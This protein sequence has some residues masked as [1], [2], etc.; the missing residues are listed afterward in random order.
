[1]KIKGVLRIGF[2]CVLFGLAPAAWAWTATTTFTVT[3]TVVPTCT[4]SAAAL[5]FGTTIP[6]PINSNVEATG[7][8]V[9]TCSS[10][11]GYAIALN[12]GN[13]SGATFASRK[14]SSGASRLNYSLFT[15]AG[16]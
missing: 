3:A 10:G 15:D 12:L 1:M 8:L 16:H 6:N 13:A 14:M 4:I 5:S 2:V 11:A 7:T 9:A